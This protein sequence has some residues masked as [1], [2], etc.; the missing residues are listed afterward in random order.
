MIEEIVAELERSDGYVSQMKIRE[1]MG[2][3]NLE[4]ID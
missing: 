2:T 4:R 1:W 3:T